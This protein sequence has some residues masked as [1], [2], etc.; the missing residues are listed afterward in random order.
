MGLRKKLEE[1]AMAVTFAEAGDFD[2]A[3]QIMGEERYFREKYLQGR[4][5]QNKGPEK[6]ISAVRPRPE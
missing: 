6:R 2:T 4:A 1:I 3:R 5:G